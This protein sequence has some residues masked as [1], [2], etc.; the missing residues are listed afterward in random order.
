[1]APKKVIII[2]SQGQD[3]TY[4]KQQVKN[5]GDSLACINNGNIDAPGQ[6]DYPYPD[7]TDFGDT[8]SMIHNFLPDEIY[9]LAAYLHSSEEDI[10]STQQLMEKSMTVHFDIPR[11]ILEAIIDR[12]RSTKFF[13]ASSSHIFGKPADSPQN[14]DTPMS[15]LSAYAFTKM[16]GLQLCR[17]H[18]KNIGIHA[19]C[20]ILYNHESP[21]RPAHFVTQRIVKEAVE[22]F[23]GTRDKIVVG[24]LNAKVDWGF[25]PDYTDAMRRIVQLEKPDDY[26]VASGKLHSVMEFI[27]IVF[28][29]IRLDWKKHIEEDNSLIKKKEIEGAPLCGDFSRLES[30]TNWRPRTGFSGMI[31]SMVEAELKND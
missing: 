31:K 6:P 7:L 1:M 14:E 23:Q 27:E 20:G 28:G 9:Y 26:I 22:I 5:A 2:G 4:L 18:R 19:S 25:A 11:V 17:F 3:G 16:L 30:A 29:I 24:N 21:L 10:P 12:K 13:Y 15:P 8:C